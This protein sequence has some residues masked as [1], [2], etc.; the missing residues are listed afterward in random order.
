MELNNNFFIFFYIFL[1]SLTISLSGCTKKEATAMLE[2]D[3]SSTVD[4]SIADQSEI[5]QSPSNSNSARHITLQG[6]VTTAYKYSLIRSGDCSSVDFSSLTEMD[7]TQN[8]IISFT[9]STD[10]TYLVCVIGKDTTGAWQSAGRA[11]ASTVLT[12]DT[13]APAL[14]NLANDS[15]WYIT[16]NWSW[17]CS[18]TCTYRYVIDTSGTTTPTGS[19]ADTSSASSSGATGTIYLHIQAKDVAGNISATTHVS[20]KIDV[21]APTNPSSLS[22]GLY[23]GLTSSPNVTFTAGTDAHSG[24]GHNESKVILSSDNSVI[25]QDWATIASNSQITGL[26]L[27]DGLQY[28]VMVRTVDSVGN[29]SAGVNSSAF[30]VDNTSPSVVSGLTLGSNPLDLTKSP[31]ISWTA[32]TDAASG[33]ASYQVQVL[34]TTDDTVMKDF[35]TLASGGQITGLSLVVQTNYYV[36]V[37]AIDNTGNIGATVSSSNWDTGGDTNIS[38][39]V[40]LAHFDESNAATS[41]TDIKGKTI[42][43][44]SCTADNTQYKFNATSLQCDGTSSIYDYVEVAT[45]TSDF[46]LSG[47]F[48]LETWFYQSAITDGQS[49]T[50]TISQANPGVVTLSSHGFSGCETVYLTTTGSLPTGLTAST[51][52]STIT[53]YYAIKIDANTFNLASSMANCVA[54]TPTA[55]N[56]TTAGS[57]THT[58]VSG[59]I[60]INNSN[61]PVSIAANTNAGKWELYV[62]DALA[63]VESTGSVAA[64]TWYHVAIVRSGSGSNNITLYVDGT[65][66]LTAT[67][68]ETLGSTTIPL[69]LASVNSTGIKAWVDDARVT[70]AA[71][72]TTTFTKPSAEYL[73]Y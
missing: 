69:T 62:N 8:P 31:T 61:G 16:K 50:A 21:T 12:F 13:T 3:Q 64:A 22:V 55:I 44:N 15:V 2:D 25:L 34:Q 23:G 73:S 49:R 72:Y 47:D 4:L 53:T 40:F 39:V 24:V 65:A 46:T 52:P 59:G 71:R 6:S 19:F 7:L 29:V 56:T 5:A 14:Q 28:K 10:G 20:A 33:V 26:T 66:K 63:A 27:T 67:S 42:T 43:N 17:N 57:G 41:F 36:K 38:S 1:L 45:A 68:T 37:R 35:S 18:E 48:T 60:N 11:L 32:A 51:F 30:T 70:K 9:P 54:T 58:L